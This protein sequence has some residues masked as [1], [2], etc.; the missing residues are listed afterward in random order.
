MTVLLEFCRDFLLRA[1]IAVGSILLVFLFMII[2][3]AI[4]KELGMYIGLVIGACFVITVLDY[5]L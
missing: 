3:L 4:G 5:L 1:G 2:G